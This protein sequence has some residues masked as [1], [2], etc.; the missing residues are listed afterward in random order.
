[1]VTALLSETHYHP[2]MK[3]I[4]MYEE[5]FAARSTEIPATNMITETVKSLTLV[6]EKI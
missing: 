4:G 2:L 5:K 6:K 3:R 1:M